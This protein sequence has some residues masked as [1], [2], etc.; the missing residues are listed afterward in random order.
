MDGATGVPVP[1]SQAKARAALLFGVPTKALADAVAAGTPIS[2][3]VTPAAATG[4]P[5][6]AVQADCRS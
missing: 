1:S 3:T 5:I 4:A 2:A 6:M